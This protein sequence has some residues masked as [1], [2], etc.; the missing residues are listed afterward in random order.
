MSTH[1]NPTM[2]LISP[3]LLIDALWFPKEAEFTA[4]RWNGERHCIELELAV[5]GWPEGEI[6]PLITEI[7][8]QLIWKHG[9]IELGR[10]E[11][12]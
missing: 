10:R 11:M 3:E 5:E 4:V 7:P 6:W 1:I 9:E 12:R 2:I 8:R